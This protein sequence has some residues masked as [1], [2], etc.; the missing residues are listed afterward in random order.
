MKKNNL[1]VI[2]LWLAVVY[3]ASTEVSNVVGIFR[4]MGLMGHYWTASTFFSL[5]S[6]AISDIFFLGVVLLWTFWC[7]KDKPTLKIPVVVTFAYSAYKVVNFFVGYFTDSYSLYSSI[8]DKLKNY[9]TIFV[10]LIAW[11]VLLIGTDYTNR[12]IFV[13]VRGILYLYSF[14]SGARSVWYNL[15]GIFEFSSFFTKLECMYSIILILLWKVL[16][17]LFLLYIAK[18]ELFYKKEMQYNNNYYYQPMN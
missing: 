11:T 5:C 9:W 17:G 13:I 10:V 2:T 16:F 8:L 4:Y 3:A 6:Q 14:I 18:P 15:E 12:L 1:G 7:W